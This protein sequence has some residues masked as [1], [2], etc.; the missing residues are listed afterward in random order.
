MN[1]IPE[2]QNSEPMLQLMRAR[3]AIYAD[4]TTYQVVQLIGTVLIPVLGAIL[5]LLWPPARPYVATISLVIAL[6]DAV[7]V[8]RAQRLALKR[9]ARVSERFDTQLFGLPWNAFVAGDPLSAE[10]ISEEAGRWRKGD[11]KLVDW[12][13]KSVGKA[14]LHL[15]RIIC[16][17]TNLWYDGSLRRAYGRWLVFGAALI[18]LGLL[19]AG[20]LS[21]L[22][23]LNLVVTVLV[24]VAPML[25]W[26][27]RESHR[28]SD[29][30]ASLE[31]VRKAAEALFDRAASDECGE[32]ECTARSREFQ[33]AIFARRSANPLVFPLVYNLLRSKMEKQMNV[34]ADALLAKAGI[35]VLQ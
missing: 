16:Q 12:Y 7:W 24:P 14:P 33:D 23:F 25:L 1:R 2:Q 20:A 35:N 17:R 29:T 31:I 27:I 26:A 22:S 28:Q 13:A 6:L 30:A 32:S 34:G 10:E 19:V 3:S 4:A 15:A 18:S 11:A 5:G 9:A 21:S 8:D